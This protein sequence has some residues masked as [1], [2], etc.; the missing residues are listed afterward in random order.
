M[1]TM[2]FSFFSLFLCITLFANAQTATKG[3][4]RKV[5][6]S[7]GY[8]TTQLNAIK[9]VSSQ[10][11]QTD[12]FYL[13]STSNALV[14]G[15]KNRTIFP[16]HLPEGTKEW[17]YRF[18]ASRIEEDITNTLK[19]FNLAGELSQYINSKN[20]LQNAVNDLTTPPGANI[21]DIYVFKEEDAKLFK[22]KEEFNYD[23]SA[24]RENYKSGT[25]L[26]KTTSSDL[27]FIGINNPDSLHGIHVAIE[28]V[29]LVENET[30][31]TETIR[32]P[33]YTSFLE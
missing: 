12:K 23:L 1:L 14:K 33:I 20:P 30:T 18:T 13:N 3:K 19:T 32:I 17:Y 11:I 26:V 2:K 10:A 15:G 7:Y 31:V 24:S 9:T 28:I 22:E 21:C 6:T 8:T 29:A 16:V 5:T 4:T 27:L 25:V